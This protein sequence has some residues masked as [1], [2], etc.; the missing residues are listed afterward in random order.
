M[1]LPRRSRP[2]R[3]IARIEFELPMLSMLPL[4]PMLRIDAKLPILSNDAALAT[5]ST[6]AKESSDRRL[7]E[8]RMD[9]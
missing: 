2:A 4:L 8:L 6:L 7:R 3:P 1:G 5:L 9:V